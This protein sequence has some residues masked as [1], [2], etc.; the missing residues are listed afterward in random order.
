VQAD[1]KLTDNTFA[2]VIQICS[3]LEGMPLGIVLAANWVTMLTT[4]EIADEIAKDLEFLESAIQDLPRRQRSLMG[5]FN[6]SWRLLSKGEQ[7]IMGA[8]SVFRRGFSRDAAREVTG[9]SLGDLK[10][11]TDQ[12][13]LHRASDGRYEIHELVRQ[14]AAEKLEMDPEAET[15]I[16]E[17]HSAYYCQALGGWERDIN[18]SRKGEA[19]QEMAI[20]IDN[21]R[22]AWKWAVEKI[23]PGSLKNGLRGLCRFYARKYQFIEGEVA[24]RSLVEK[25]DL[26]SDSEQIG[27][28][29]DAD[30]NID[31]IDRLKLIALALAWQGGFNVVTGNQTRGRKLAQ[32]S[33]SII[34]Q[35]E[36]AD[37][38]V[39]YA[40]GV[41]LKAMEW[42]LHIESADAA[43]KLAQESLDCFRSLGD[44]EWVANLL[45]DLGHIT[46][47]NVVESRDFYQ[48]SLAIRRKMGDLWGITNSLNSLAQLA[49]QQGQFGKAEEMVVECLAI[50]TEL[51][52]RLDVMSVY[53]TLVKILTWQGK[54]AE[55]R[56]LE[57]EILAAHDDLANTQNHSVLIFSQAGV[58][59]QYLGNYEAARSQ[60]KHAIDLFTE[61]DLLMANYGI[62]EAT[63]T[64][65]RVALA[66]RSFTDA[67]DLFN[68][69]I[70]VFNTL[71]GDLYRTFACQGY[72]ARGLNRIAQAQE[73][74]LEA[75][76]AATKHDDFPPLIHAL[77]GIALLFADQ[78]EAERAVELYAL[79]ST[80]G[81]VANSKWFDDIAGDEIAAVAEGLPEDVIEAAKTRGRSLDLWET[82]AELLDELEAL[83]WGSADQQSDF[84]AT[85]IGR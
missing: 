56:A 33:L 3:L 27:M 54:F 25:L 73:H 7:K 2:D 42:V 17:K 75:L 31:L 47:S 50:V 22:V 67:D 72:A 52:D 15:D 13:M 70:P 18:S 84:R 29:C 21:I 69:C 26:A 62:A 66:E 32:R 16:R 57:R 9:A 43:K 38:D 78:G 40:K 61:M 8:L 65:G 55:A 80:F 64:L 5:V 36:L 35:P 85:T 60:A 14:Y 58:P 28:D 51:G 10:G 6:H 24:C 46:F 44:K 4:A 45:N 30:G 1:Y 39:R 63:S 83:G 41:A 79:A 76:R 19:L 53:G 68:E 71:S 81:I 20:E 77:P 23:R 74:F 11:L 48:E 49:A 82:V 12:S 59:D 37:Q 34:E